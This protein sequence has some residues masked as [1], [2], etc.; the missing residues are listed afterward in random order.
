MTDGLMTDEGRFF[1]DIAE[2]LKAGRGAAYRAVNAVMVE[3]YWRMGQRIV[4]QEQ[5]GKARAG[6]GDELMVRLSRYL[7]EN[8][9]KGFSIA[10]LWN[11]R[12]FYMTFPTFDEFSTH[13][14]GNLG[15][16]MS[17]HGDAEAHADRRH[18]STVAHGHQRPMA[19]NSVFIHSTNTRVR[20]G[21][22]RACG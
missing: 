22:H 1:T 21:N 7:G 16:T 17:Q 11:F 10:N 13:C 19:A 2:I 4:E 6:Y 15:W 3:T 8:F 5:Q 9:G 12:Q 14:V 20:A 18:R